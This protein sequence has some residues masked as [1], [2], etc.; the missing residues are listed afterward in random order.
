MCE[1]VRASLC[2]LSVGLS[3]AVFW[4]FWNHYPIE[5]ASWVH[6]SPAL[7]WIF[8]ILLTPLM[9][10]LLR[11]R[12]EKLVWPLLVGILLGWLCTPISLFVYEY[13]F[14][15]PRLYRSLERYPIALLGVGASLA[16]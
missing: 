8:L 9:T 15:A 14:E 12:L 11:E 4:M 10:A 5:A 7:V 16:R 6:R 1:K 2:I 3:C 13:L